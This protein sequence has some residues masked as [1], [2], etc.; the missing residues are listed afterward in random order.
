MATIH[1]EECDDACYKS[2]FTFLLVETINCL[3]LETIV[4][5]LCPLVVNTHEEDFD[6]AD[7]NMTVAK[8]E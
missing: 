7:H 3:G 2:Q 4:S 5:H 6:D 1:E 8:A